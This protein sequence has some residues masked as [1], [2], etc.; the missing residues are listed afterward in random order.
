MTKSLHAVIIGAAIQQ[1]LFDLN[2]QA[3]LEDFTI[4]QKN[5]ILLKNNGKAITI[6]DLIQMYDII[7]FE[8]FY[9]VYGTV[10]HMLFVAQDA[11]LFAAEA[12]KTS[13]RPVNNNAAN[14][15]E[16]SMNIDWYYSSGVSNILAK[17]FR[18]YFNSDEEYINFP[19][20]YLFEPCGIKNFIIGVDPSGMHVIN[21][22]SNLIIIYLIL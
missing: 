17:E 6:G 10:P 9:G 1:G 18:S 13:T 15:K 22:V 16:F 3:K 5:E 7:P 8:E 12:S 11:G 2:T 21:I 14:D 4:E 19:N 20:K